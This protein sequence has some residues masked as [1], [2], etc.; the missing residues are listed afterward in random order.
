[1]TMH[2]R[3]TGTWR[4]LT[5]VYARVAGTWRRATNAYVKVGGVWQ[6]VFVNKLLNATMTVGHYFY[7]GDD[8]WGFGVTF[9]DST[10][11]PGSMTPT[12][13]DVGRNVQ[14]LY[15]Y[16]FDQSVRL[17]VAGESSFAFTELVVNG[18]VFPKSSALEVL[19]SGTGRVRYDWEPVANPFGTVEGATK[20]IIIR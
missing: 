16:S 12:M 17:E 7:I 9:A 18:V 1:M 6:E 19:S 8:L 4:E 13:T 10:A 3:V 11:Y 5:K 20:S 2:T 14:A 15:W